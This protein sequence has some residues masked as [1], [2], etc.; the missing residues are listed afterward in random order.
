MLI[1]NA[2]C[3]KLLKCFW[4]FELFLCPNLILNVS[5]I[6][7][8]VTDRHNGM[9]EQNKKEVKDNK[10]AKEE[11]RE[12]GKNKTN[13]NEGAFGHNWHVRMF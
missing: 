5:L 10:R 11:L 9:V 13:T 1:E 8:W 4:H 3:F 7:K 12:W 6:M 2:K